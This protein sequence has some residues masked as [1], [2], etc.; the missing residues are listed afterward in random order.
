MHRLQVCLS[1][2]TK[3]GVEVIPQRTRNAAIAAYAET[4][5]LT[6]R[7]VF[8]ALQR[9]FGIRHAILEHDGLNA[10][11]VFGAGSSVRIS[12]QFTVFRG[13]PWGSVA[14]GPRCLGLR[15]LVSQRTHILAAAP[16]EAIDGCSVSAR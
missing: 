9:H 7:T 14:A 6:E 5:L 16:T 13:R 2:A 3:R 10:F 11:E 1:S 12:K 8:R 15:V 4:S